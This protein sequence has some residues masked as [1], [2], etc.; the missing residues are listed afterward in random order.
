MNIPVIVLTKE[1]SSQEIIE[2]YIKENSEFSF[3]ASTDDFD[4]AYCAIS[5]LKQSLL[6]IDIS[7]EEDFA[8]DF[9]KKSIEQNPDC[10][11][12]ALTENYKTE[13]IIKAMREGVI[14]IL[15]IPLIKEQFSNALQNVINSITGEKIQK[16]KCKTISVFSN[17]GGVGKT[18]L[19]MNL[20]LELAKNT[21]ENVV[22]VDLNFQLGDITTFWDLKPNFNISYMLKNID[23]LNQNFLL[24]T[25][26]KYKNTNLYILADP[27]YFKQADYVAE[28]DIITLLNMLKSTFSYIVIDTTSGFGN[29]TIKALEMSDMILLLTTMNLPAL[30]NSQRC[31]ELFN[32]LNF[33]SDK[34]KILI[35]RYMESEDIK[36]EDVE[37]LLKK[38]V[39]WK[40]PNNYFTM[41]SAINLGIPV[42][43]INRDSNVARSYK[44]LSILISDSIYKRI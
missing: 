43:E 17:K 26:E 2:L 10:K 37:Q 25:I 35:N 27:P 38:K 1:K 20:A 11:V 42:A 31:L 41:M 34:V 13:T 22:L 6:V 44:D 18:S 39:F 24:N 32:S 8:I 40:I 29:K 15:T 21:K 33:N 4:K 16:D 12:I 9:I 5:E 3:L 28:K 23:K 19:A 7:E 14:E 36:V 30:R